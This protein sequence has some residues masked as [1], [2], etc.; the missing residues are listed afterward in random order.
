MKNIL[1]KIL[2]AE[3]ASHLCLV[4]WQVWFQLLIKQNN[5]H[6]TS[7]TLVP[8]TTWSCGTQDMRFMQINN[9]QIWIS[10]TVNESSLLERVKIQILN[11]SQIHWNHQVF[12]RFA[13]KPMWKS[14]YENKFTKIS[15]NLSRIPMKNI[16]KWFT[17]R[18][19]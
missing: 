12:C 7:I 17:T 18:I 2:K 11:L 4:P 16:H 6:I 1:A 3:I 10:S 13:A 5:V 8:Q 15:K 14:I 19:V 9:P